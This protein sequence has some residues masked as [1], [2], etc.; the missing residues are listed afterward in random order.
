MKIRTRSAFTLVE[1]LVVIAIIG[2]LVSLLLP[3]VQSAREAARRMS[4]QNNLKQIGL[5]MHNYHDTYGKL[6]AGMSAHPGSG[7]WSWAVH[8]MPFM[9]LNTIHDQINFQAAPDDASNSVIIQT[10]VP[11]Y[12]CP[13]SPQP[14]VNDDPS[15]PLQATNSYAASA[16]CNM[17]IPS[18]CSN[19]PEEAVFIH[20]RQFGFKDITD[21]LSNTIMVGEVQWRVGPYPNGSGSVRN[22]QHLYG[23]HVDGPWYAFGDACGTGTGDGDVDYRRTFAVMRVAG[24]PINNVHAGGG[25]WWDESTHAFGSS[26]PGGAQ[27]VYGDGSVQYLSENIEHRVNS[28][29]PNASG[30]NLNV[31]NNLGRALWQRLNAKND[32]LPLGE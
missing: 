7:G 11:T 27:F 12:L 2:V 17:Y 8:I 26:H 24:W 23:G 3:A 30:G 20:Q 13:S 10:V 25:T 1:L 14:Q 16:G 18:R 6:P 31:A 15:L 5:A 22:T 9:E 29:W 4:C 32:N 21:G 19:D 28:W